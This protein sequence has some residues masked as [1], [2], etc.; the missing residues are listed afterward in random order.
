MRLLISTGEVSGDLQG[1]FLVK[2]LFEEAKRRSIHLE[3]YALGG[4]RMR[5]AGAKLIANTSSIGAI[6]F[7]EAIP[8]IL[9][10]LRVQSKLNKLL[11]KYPLDGVVLI[12]YMGPNIRLGNKVKK[13]LKDI[14]VIYYIAPQEWA[15]RLGDGGTTDLIGFTDKILAIFKAEADFYK[16]KGGDVTWVGHPMLDNFKSMPTRNDSFLKLGLSPHQ[17]LLLLFPASR[18]Q[19]LKYLMPTLAEAASLLQK[20]YSS[21]F[22]LVPAGLESFEKDLNYLLQKYGVN[23]RVIPAKEVD[24]LKP[25]LFSAA[26]LALGK[27]GTINMELALNCVP[28]IVGYKVSKVTA[29]FAKKILR[30]NVDHISPV[31]LL[32]NQRVIPE[33]LQD[34]FTSHRIYQ[35]A[36]SLLDDPY[37]IEKIN[38]GYKNL[39]DELGSIGVTE[40]AS[41][42]IFNLFDR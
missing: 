32:L 21:L 33:L 36:T 8:F 12:D 15:W 40:R 19:E 41:K 31:N 20:R 3:I 39:R 13:F 18:S 29:F 22:V 6:G 27:S 38:I 28:Q 23:G 4:D 14:P 24:S 11:K 5:K 17:K 30:F 35:E 10:T 42:E 2:S 9:P 16:R 37:K 34:E 26:S 25:F 7:L 1:S